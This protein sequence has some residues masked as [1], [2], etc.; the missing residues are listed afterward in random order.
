MKNL[1][2]S[3]SLPGLLAAFGVFLLGNQKLVA[4][5]TIR[6]D[7]TVSV[8]GTLTDT[9]TRNFFTRE[10]D[11]EFSQINA[12]YSLYA[13]QSQSITNGTQNFGGSNFY[14]ALTASASYAITGGTQNFEYGSILEANAANAI[15][16]GTQ[17]FAN[18]SGLRANASDAISNGTQNFVNGSNLAITTDRAIT[19]G[20]QN[21]SNG[22]G[23]QI[24]FQ[25]GEY[26]DGAI[27]G[28]TQNFQGGGGPFDVVDISSIRA[29][30]GGTQ[31]FY[32]AVDVSRENAI[33]GGVQNVIG[34]TMRV[35][36]TDAIV[37]TY[38]PYGGDPSLTPT[39]LSILSSGTL[40]VSAQRAI[41]GTKIL[42]G[43]GHSYSSSVVDIQADNA[44]DR[45]VDLQFDFNGVQSFNDPQPTGGTVFL[46]GHTL[47]VGS[48][49]GGGRGD[50]QNGPQGVVQYGFITNDGSATQAT[51]VIDTTAAYGVG[52]GVRIEDG[53]GAAVN[54]VVRGTGRQILSSGQGYTG[55]TTVENAALSVN[56]GP[57]TQQQ[58]T[59]S[60]AGLT[61]SAGALQIDGVV[62]EVYAGNNTN[63]SQ[64]FSGLTVGAGASV[65]DVRPNQSTSLE[66]NLGNIA[67]LTRA[68]GGTM[69][70]RV[71]PGFDGWTG[72]SYPA[73]GSVK[74]SNV[75]SDTILPWATL[76]YGE[77]FAKVDAGG[78]SQVTALTAF[79]TTR[80]D[81]NFN[82]TAG[83]LQFPDAAAHT[84]ANDN[85]EKF[86][87][88]LVGQAV[89]NHTARVDYTRSTALDANEELIFHQYNFN[90]AAEF[91][92]DVTLDGN[93]A[94]FLLTKTGGGTLIVGGVSSRI[95]NGVTSAANISLQINEG[96]VITDLAI[97]GDVVLK[98][99]GS[100]G[101]NA[102]VNGLVK[103]GG[104]GRLL[105]GRSPG[106]LTAATAEWD[107]GG[108]YVWEINS[109]TGTAG[110]VSGGWDLLDVTGVLDITAT[111]ANPFVIDI[112]TLTLG[113]VA[114]N[115]ANFNQYQDY[116]WTIAT[117]AGGITGFNT[118]AFTLDKTDFTND[119]DNIYGVFSLALSMDS[120]DLNLVYTYSGPVSVPEPSTWLIMLVGV[121]TAMALVRRRSKGPTRL[122]QPS[123]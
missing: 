96:D 76:S 94:S 108:T 105:P 4:D 16:G 58:N 119:Y 120:K 78:T 14:S 98:N 43:D 2:L 46:N 41:T 39:V 50:V 47:T 30:T 83:L 28:G 113:N 101:G 107:G 10:N 15:D 100:L 91:S 97:A 40:E 53:T 66:V 82:S 85:G 27:T 103:V 77:A 34:G 38:V 115:M 122:G 71:Q 29:I 1:H 79:D 63:Y 70:F 9:E 51:L 21:F 65:L 56:F 106:T 80:N 69:D 37:G 18:G 48:L 116:S 19:G 121:G 49:Y 42:L 104:G 54:L 86:N 22:N 110:L 114:G 109:A 123:C 99:G 44:L 7:Y 32:S 33:I 17:N 3:S 24:S 95:V 13:D 55:T 62:S 12:A 68:A 20:T 45:T 75:G 25:W 26:Y 67:N 92:Y 6:S 112:N 36:A 90:K 60:T 52:S 73:A 5:I 23:A 59:I 8:N 11:E 118:N 102:V 111:F 84:V 57:N 61:L 88:V 74:F 87:A 31:N 93:A 89:G 81:V 72:T 64:N 117:A 35:T